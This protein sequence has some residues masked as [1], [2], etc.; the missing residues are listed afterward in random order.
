MGTGTLEARVKTTISRAFRNGWPKCS[1]IRA[2]RVKAGQ[3]LARLD[4][5]ETRQQVAIAEATLAAARRT[6]A[7]ARRPGARGGGAPPGAAGSQAVHRACGVQIAA[8][9]DFDKAA[10]ALRVAEADLKRSHAAIVEARARC[11]PPER[12]LLFRRSTLAFTEIHSPYDG[13]V[14]RRDRDPGGVCRAGCI[15][16]QLI[17]STKSGSALGAMRPPS[18]LATDATGARRLPLR[19]ATRLPGRSRA[20]RT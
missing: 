13:L 11:S 14:T 4:D 15:L 19:A 5:A 20:T 1:S 12:S 3:L 8:Q 2:T 9:S 18:A 6:R 10:E 7:R 17:A 16:L